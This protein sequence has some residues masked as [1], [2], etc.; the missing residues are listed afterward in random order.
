[1]CFIVHRGSGLQVPLLVFHVAWQKT[2]TSLCKHIS[3]WEHT[4][5]ERGRVDVVGK[6]TFC[7]QRQSTPSRAPAE[8]RLTLKEC[9]KSHIQG[10]PV[11]QNKTKKQ[12]AYC[13]ALLPKTKHCSGAWN[14]WEGT[15]RPELSEDWMHSAFLNSW[16]TAW[17]L[18]YI[19]ICARV[20]VCGCMR[21]C[22]SHVYPQ[23]F[24]AFL[25]LQGYRRDARE[26]FSHC[27]TSLLKQSFATGAVCWETFWV[28]CFNQ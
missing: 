16:I 11:Y 25:T 28:W 12:L 13:A 1:M 19:E 9:W 26:K 4:R 18:P 5:R 6:N 17:R 3:A 10:R 20:C 14:A 24:L 23:G 2:V 7:Q 8:W 21:V 22:V 27:E 15:Q